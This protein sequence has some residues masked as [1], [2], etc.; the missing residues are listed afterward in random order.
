MDIHP[1]PLGMS[2]SGYARLLR[3]RRMGNVS[4]WHVRFKA[5]VV[6][7]ML[8]ADETADYKE[9][10][11]IPVGSSVNIVGVTAKSN[12]GEFSILCSSVTLV[13]VC[14]T[15]LPDKHEGLQPGKRYQD[16]VPRLLAGDESF[17]MFARIARGTQAIRQALWKRGFREFPT[18]VLT[19]GRNAG[20]AELFITRCNANGKDYHL[21]LTSELKLKKLQIAGFDDVF[22]IFQSFRNEG[23]DSMH[24]PEFTLLEVGKTGADCADMMRLLE[25]LLEEFAAFTLGAATVTVGEFN[26]S[27]QAPYRRISFYDAC[28]Q[29]LGIPRADCTL[30]HL[31]SLYPEYFSAGMTTFTWVFKVVNRLLGPCSIEEPTFITEIPSG[32]SPLVRENEADPTVTDRAALLIAGIDIADV[33][34]DENDPERVERAMQR[35]FAEAGVPVNED[36]LRVLQYGMPKSGSIG[37]GMNRLFMLMLGNLPDNIK[38]TILFP[39]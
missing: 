38:E 1:F 39:L 22:E 16:V 18:G 13:A 2:M 11:K 3:K 4:F 26:I 32:I 27:L 20:N 37:M 5:V 31:T 29:W 25:E 34:A 9:V 30:E 8:T 24:S 35:Q 17:E 36:Y 12:S 7:L 23:V 21:T 33:Y 15:H 19:R 6:Q 14:K 28:E 10:V